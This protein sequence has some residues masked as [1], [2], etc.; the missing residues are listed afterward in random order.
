M[1]IAV[2][3]DI[4]EERRMLRDRLEHSLSDHSVHADIYEFENGESFLAASEKERFTVAFNAQRLVSVY[5][6]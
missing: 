5:G 6:R 3:D 4:A 1:R 2:A